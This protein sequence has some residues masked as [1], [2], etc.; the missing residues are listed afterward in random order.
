MNA[1]ART[2]RSILLKCTALDQVHHQLQSPAEPNLVLLAEDSE[3]TIVGQTD[4]IVLATGEIGEAILSG[5]SVGEGINFKDQLCRNIDYFDAKCSGKFN[6]EICDF[7]EH[8][9]DDAYSAQVG[10][11]QCQDGEV[12]IS[13]VNQDVSVGEEDLRALCHSHI[14]LTSPDPHFVE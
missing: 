13:I 9:V 8:F 6:I 14:P 10:A 11:R 7:L 2:Y 3:V 1:L 5:E 4:P 12:R